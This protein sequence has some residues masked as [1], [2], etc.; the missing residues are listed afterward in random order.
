MSKAVRST[1]QGVHADTTLNVPTSQSRIQSTA[2]RLVVV[3][4]VENRRSDP[5]C[6]A[7]Q[8]GHGRLPLHALGIAFPLL[9]VA[10]ALLWG[11]L[12][13]LRDGGI[14]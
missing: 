5:S 14:P 7:L 9:P 13:R 3:V 1:Y 6:M 8:H 10:L 4:P 2:I 11:N 12:V